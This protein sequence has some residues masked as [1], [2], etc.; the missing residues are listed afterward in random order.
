[1]SNDV[2]EYRPPNVVFDDEDKQAV[3]EPLLAAHPSG[4]LCLLSQCGTH[5][6]QSR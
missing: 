6:A 3:A 5:R 1:M 4:T 2:G